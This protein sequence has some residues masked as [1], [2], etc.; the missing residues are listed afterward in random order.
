MASV[1]LTAREPGSISNLQASDEKGTT[2]GSFDLP[3]VQLEGREVVNRFVAGYVVI[4]KEDSTPASET[5]GEVIASGDIDLVSAQKT[6]SFTKVDQAN[7]ANLFITVFIKNAAGS[8][9]WTSGQVIN[10]VPQV[11]P[12]RPASDDDYTEISTVYE[13][14]TFVVPEDGWFKVV[15]TGRGV[16]GSTDTYPR[17]IKYK[18]TCQVKC[19]SKLEKISEGEF[20]L[21]HLRG[22]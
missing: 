20:Q 9:F 18:A 17:D 11:F 10:I 14:G 13:S 12:D 7:G 6:V 22:R 15:V 19:N 21:R 3:T 1:I 4:Q 16:D 2:T 5:D 8:Y